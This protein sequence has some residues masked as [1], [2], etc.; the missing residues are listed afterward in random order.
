MVDFS[1]PLVRLPSSDCSEEKIKHVFFR[2]PIDI[3]TDLRGYFANEV[4]LIAYGTRI[5]LA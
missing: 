1:A 4:Y 2:F 3:S 5:R